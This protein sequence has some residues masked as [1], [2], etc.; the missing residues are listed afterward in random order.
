MVYKMEWKEGTRIK[1]DAE[2]IGKELKTLGTELTTANIVEK[3][4]DDTTELYKCFEWNDKEAAVEYRKEQA[5]HL[6]RS[7]IIIPEDELESDEPAQII[8]AYESVKTEDGH[9]FVPI[10]QILS[11]EDWR[12]EVFGAIQK[13][14]DELIRKLEVYQ[15]MSGIEHKVI[16][17]KEVL[18][19]A[20]DLI[21]A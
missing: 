21:E 18:E 14:I 15:N 4:R 20:R 5:R 3:A 8:R 9:A 16:K 19:T 1:A 7:L 13:S 10:K 17:I 12:K 11:N 6:L 2:K